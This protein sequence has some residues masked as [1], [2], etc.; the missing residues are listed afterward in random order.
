LINRA[1]LG[2]GFAL[3]SCAQQPPP[4][5]PSP[6]KFTVGN[7]YQAGGESLIIIALRGFPQ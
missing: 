6:P 2:L 3:A 5:P 7:A 1:I 4:P